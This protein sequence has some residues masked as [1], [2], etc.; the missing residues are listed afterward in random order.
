MRKVRHP[1][2]TLNPSVPGYQWSDK[3]WYH[4]AR[5]MTN[6]ALFDRVDRESLSGVYSR[7]ATLQHTSQARHLSRITGRDVTMA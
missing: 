2:S 4:L 6:N 5:G 7:V 1:L 3:I